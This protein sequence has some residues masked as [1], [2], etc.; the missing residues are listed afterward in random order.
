MGN[1]K[2][3]TSSQDDDYALGT[4]SSLDD[5]RNLDGL[6]FYGELEDSDGDL[7]GFADSILDDDFDYDDDLTGRDVAGNGPESEGKGALYDAYNQLHTLAQVSIM[8]PC[9][10]KELN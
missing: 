7:E 8:R 2:R 4:S 10:L 3:A 5:D 9:L 6:D 1:D